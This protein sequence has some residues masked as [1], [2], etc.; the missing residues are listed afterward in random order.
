MEIKSGMIVQLKTGSP[1]MT[2]HSLAR[3]ET[4][5]CSWFVGTKV[6]HSQF[7]TDQLT[8]KDPNQK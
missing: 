6:N 2:V 7:R 3:P 4:W 1:A 8:D 5:I